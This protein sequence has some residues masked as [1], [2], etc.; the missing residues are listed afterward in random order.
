M[1][2]AVHAL[3][4]EAHRVRKTMFTGLLKD[5]A[6]LRAFGEHPG[7]RWAEAVEGRQRGLIV[8]FDEAAAV[9]AQAVCDWAG[10]LPPPLQR[11]FAAAGSYR[12]SGRHHGC[13]SPAS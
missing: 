12:G 11:P 1:Q 9:L 5:G 2:G 13:H 7:R 8:L 4:G 6:G 3:D 10:V